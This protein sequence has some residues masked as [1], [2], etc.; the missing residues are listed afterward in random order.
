MI[1]LPPTPPQKN[2][3]FLKK[4]N[5]FNRKKYSLLVP[6]YFKGELYMSFLGST[7]IHVMLSMM[8][9]FFFHIQELLL[10]VEGIGHVANMYPYQGHDHGMIH[11]TLHNLCGVKKLRFRVV[12]IL[13]FF[14]VIYYEVGPNQL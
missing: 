6:T 8:K 9:G 10:N 5:H 12:E 4:W 13:F 11:I 7:Q 2:N 14:A 1:Y 3:M